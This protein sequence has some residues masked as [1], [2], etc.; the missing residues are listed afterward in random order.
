M[1]TKVSL[2]SAKK[3]GIFICFLVNNNSSNIS[4]EVVELLIR[5]TVV[6]LSQHTLGQTNTKAVGTGRLLVR[7]PPPPSLK[8]QSDI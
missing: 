2:T 3:T 1:V 8:D 7:S 4:S 6:A 5:T